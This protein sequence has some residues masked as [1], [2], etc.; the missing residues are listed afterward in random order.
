[1]SKDLI[2]NYLSEGTWTDTCPCLTASSRG[3]PPLSSLTQKIYNLM[4]SKK[5]CPHHITPICFVATIQPKDGKNAVY[6][7]KPEARLRHL[8]LISAA[9]STKNS[10]RFWCPSDDAICCNQQVR[11]AQANIQVTLPEPFC[12]EYPQHLGIFRSWSAVE[13]LQYW[14][15]TLPG[16]SQ[17]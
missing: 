6:R 2:R 16:G 11:H 15:Q 9:F 3:D 4:L 14:H 8:L 5:I 17:V 13:H 10:T 7:L 12:R 1:M